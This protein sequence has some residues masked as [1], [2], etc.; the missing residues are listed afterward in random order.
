MKK[1]III[2]NSIY[3]YEEVKLYLGRKI[4]DPEIAKK[5]LLDFKKVMDKHGIIFR[6]WF[7]TLLGAIREKKFIEYDE[8]ID[9]CILEEDRGKVLNSLFDLERLGL[10][11]VRFNEKKG[12][13]SIM[14]DGDYIDIY[15]YR[16]CFRKRRMGNNTID[17]KYLERMDTV[18]FLGESFSVPWNTKE[19]LRILYG[20]DW[21]IPNK[22][23]KPMNKSL[24]LKIKHFLII[25]LPV[26]YKIY[27]KYIK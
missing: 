25:R 27:T 6:L 15:F 11:V 24:D 14:R 2:D 17:A 19:V 10:K 7:G 18:K 16:K 22:N 12:L 23:G 3:S 4:I 20:E 5:N 21:N 9:V 8:D 13:L 1:E 26:L